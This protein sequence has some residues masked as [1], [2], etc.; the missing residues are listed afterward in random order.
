MLGWS[1]EPFAM[2][3]GDYFVARVGE[4]FAGGVTGLACGALPEAREPYWFSF[5]SVADVDAAI[6]R[7]LALGGS[8]V[9]AVVDVPN[10]G[11][12]AIVRDPQ[13]GADRLDDACRLSLT[14]RPTG[15]R[16]WCGRA[17]RGRR[18]GSRAP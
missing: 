8:I 5:I 10:V 3:D 11:R 15:R 7:A 14:N 6:A 16:R 9:R 17:A 4:T 1:F 2:P 18:A 12:V 13:G